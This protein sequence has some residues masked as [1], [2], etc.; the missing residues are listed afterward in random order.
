MTDDEH[1]RHTV[2]LGMIAVDAIRNP[3]WDLRECGPSE[4]RDNLTMLKILADG[5]VKLAK[6]Q[7]MIPTFRVPAGG[8]S[9]V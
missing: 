3:E 8:A 4:Y 6:R 2:K 1:L 7:D 9:D 5:F